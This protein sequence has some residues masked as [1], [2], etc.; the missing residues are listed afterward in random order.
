MKRRFLNTIF[1][2]SMLALSIEATGTRVYLKNGDVI[3]GQ[4]TQRSERTVTIQTTVSELTLPMSQVDRID[5]GE[6]GDTE[7]FQAR[8]MIRKNQLAEAERFLRLAEQAGAKPEVLQSVRVEI[9]TLRDEAEMRRYQELIERARAAAQRGE[10]S[11]AIVELEGLLS[12]LGQDSQARQEIIDIL[13]SFHLTNAENFTDRVE[14]DD[15]VEELRRVIELDPSRPEAYAQLGDIYKF[16]TATYN[17]ATRNYIKA[18]QIGEESLSRERKGAICWETAE[19]YRQL[20]KKKEAAEYYLKTYELTPELNLRLKDRFQESFL[21]FAREIISDKPEH[22]LWMCEKGLEAGRNF[23]LL[24]LKAAALQSMAKK[25]ESEEKMKE[26]LNRS[27]ETYLALIEED[28][29]RRNVYFEIAQNHFTLEEVLKGREALQKEIEVWPKNYNAHCL[30][31]DYALSRDDYETA[32]KH[33]RIAFDV[34]QDLSRASI[35]LGRTLRLQKELDEAKEALDEVLVRWPEDRLANLEMGRIL[36]DEQEYD[37]AKEFFTEVLRLIEEDAEPEERKNLAQL[38]ADAY[39]ARGEINLLTAG[40]GTASADFRK[41][42][43]VLPEYPEAFYSIG[44]AYRKKYGTSKNLSDLETAEENFLE[45]M[46]L[47]PENHEY[48]L[49]LG[50]LYAEDLAQVDKD[51]EQE[52]IQKAVNCWNRYIDMGGPNAGQVRTWIAEIGS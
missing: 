31:A 6:P 40:P 23:E 22:A 42:L 33:Y 45:A 7:I 17:E 14:L 34:N 3:E 13:C 29:D 11:N 10:K 2:T 52:Y 5:E 20:N 46:Q 32:E 25:T 47:D 49:D 37:E 21:A 28:E 18:L 43:E 8:E 16:A 15:A 39:L 36:R 9:K 4:V 19:I 35:G 26:L 44:K 12:Q 48:I 38:E 30:I 41:A 24:E 27:T 50:I 1:L 51:K